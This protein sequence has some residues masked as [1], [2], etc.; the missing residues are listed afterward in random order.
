MD[1][2]S[3]GISRGRFLQ[4]LAQVVYWSTGSNA[5]HIRGLEFEYSILALILEFESRRWWDCKSV[6]KKKGD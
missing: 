4:Y 6:P 3:H 5:I 1:P 2:V